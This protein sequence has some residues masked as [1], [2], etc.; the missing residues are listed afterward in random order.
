MKYNKEQI[1]RIKGVVSKYFGKELVVCKYGDN[2]SLMNFNDDFTLS[3]E[4]AKKED[5]ISEVSVNILPKEK[6]NIDR[7]VIRF[8]PLKIK[9]GKDIFTIEH[10]AKEYLNDEE[11][12]IST[13]EVRLTKPYYLNN[14]MI[15]NDSRVINNLK[16]ES[17]KNCLALFYRDYKKNADM[18]SYIQID[19]K[20]KEN[21]NGLNIVDELAKHIFEIK[22][23]TNVDEKLIYEIIKVILCQRQLDDYLIT[24]REEIKKEADMNFTL[25]KFK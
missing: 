13:S 14:S 15:K 18:N 10:Y 3:I 9:K 16:I 23:N 24:E 19:S 4:K 1:E 21:F 7:Y 2:V 20:L 12:F 6:Q 8:S 17:Q 11:S 25:L 5:K 22:K